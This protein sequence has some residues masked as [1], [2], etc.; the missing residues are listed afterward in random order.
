M[1][2]PIDYTLYS[3]EEIIEIVGF[4][5]LLEQNQAHPGMLP[6]EA[7]KAAYARFRAVVN[8]PA[9]E[10]KIAKA[11]AKQTGIR[12]DQLIGNLEKSTS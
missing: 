1:D 2:Y 5:H 7:L 8:S 6:A 4:L 3:T 10:K 9:E 11:F 12:I